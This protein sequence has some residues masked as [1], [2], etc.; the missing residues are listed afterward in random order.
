[1]PGDTAGQMAN[2]WTGRSHAREA[3]VAGKELDGLAL[4]GQHHIELQANATCYL[5][6]AEMLRSSQVLGV[7][8]GDVLGLIMSKVLKDFTE[9]TPF[10]GEWEEIDVSRNAVMLLGHGFVDP[11]E[12]RKNQKVKVLPA[13]G[14]WGFEGNSLGFQTSYEPGPVTMTHVIQD[15]NGWRMLISEGKILDTPP[16]KIS[17]SSVIVEV[18]KNVKEYFRELMKF[19]FPHHCIAAPG[20]AGGHLACFAEQCGIKPCWL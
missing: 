10:F 2:H 1:M 6:L 5:G 15:I 14:D 4:L 20:R 11:R 17:E 16:M 7:A 18:Q 9:H 8:E 12:A 19:G 13:C 3:C